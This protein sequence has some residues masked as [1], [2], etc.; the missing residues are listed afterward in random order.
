MKD[1][2]N[3]GTGNLLAAYQEVQKLGLLFPLGSLTF[4]DVKQT[5]LD[6]A[7]YDPFQLPEALLSGNAVRFTKILS[8]LQDEGVAPPL[9]LWVLTEEVNVLLKIHYGLKTGQALASVL[10]DVRVH[11]S[12]HGL[13]TAAIKRLSIERLLASLRH[14][15]AIDKLIKGLSQGNVW[16]ELA[17]FGLRFCDKPVCATGV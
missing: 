1:Q 8:G 2:S 10:R 11:T 4:D 3:Y 7:R 17:Q 6:V 5:V 13:V 14:A 12:R 16:D 15:A 9:I